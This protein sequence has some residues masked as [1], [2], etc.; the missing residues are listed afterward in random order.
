MRSQAHDTLESS[1]W[2]KGSIP[3]PLVIQSFTY[4]REYYRDFEHLQGG[5]RRIL[6]YEFEGQSF[7]KVKKNSISP[8]IS[9]AWMS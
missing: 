9:K 2:G 5:I 4:P 3:Y 7:H 8:A 6:E 1:C